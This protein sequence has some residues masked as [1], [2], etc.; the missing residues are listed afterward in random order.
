MIWIYV[1]DGGGEGQRTSR[2]DAH[3]RPNHVLD[4]QV[5][6]W[7]YRLHYQRHD[8]SVGCLH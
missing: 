1:L 3:V 6:N 2:R 5:S 7:F 4:P 8:G